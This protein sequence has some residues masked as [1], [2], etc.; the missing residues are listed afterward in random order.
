VRWRWP[1][2]REVPENGHD[3]AEAREEAAKALREAE[4]RWPE[5]NQFAAQVEAAFARR[6]QR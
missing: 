3:A 5:V 1:W 4:R 6:R 2:R